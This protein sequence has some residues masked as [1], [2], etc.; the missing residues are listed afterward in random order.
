VP[1]ES[2]GYNRRVHANCENLHFL[3]GDPLIK[4]LELPELR[5]AKG[6]PVASIEKVKCRPFPA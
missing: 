5:R 6:S 3:G 2:V 1:A 4:F